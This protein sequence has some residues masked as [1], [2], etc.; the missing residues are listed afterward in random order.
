MAES[1]L[2][3]MQHTL[4]L[5]FVHVWPLHVKHADSNKDQFRS[6]VT[7]GDLKAKTSNNIFNTIFRRKPEP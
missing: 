5:L 7:N 6:S 4:S 3:S 2:L 1:L